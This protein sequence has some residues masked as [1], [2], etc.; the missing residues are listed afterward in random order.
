MLSMSVEQASGYGWTVAG[1]LE[2]W[3]VRR[4]PYLRATTAASYRQHIRDYLIPALGRIR[5]AELGLP[6]FQAMFWDLAVVHR[7]N[8][9]LSANSL[10]R[11]RATLRSALSDACG[12]G[13]IREN[14]ASMVR[15]PGWR[16]RYLP[17]PDDV[18]EPDYEFF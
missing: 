9:P 5:L 17:R 3:L 11:I 6:A 10:Q 14:L 12:A 8:G 1:W 4:M 15:I 13:L 16:R 18:P 7:R 2:A